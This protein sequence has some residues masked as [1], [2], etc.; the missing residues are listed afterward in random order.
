MFQLCKN[1]TFLGL[2]FSP[3]LHVTNGDRP[4]PFSSF[5]NPRTI[6]FVCRYAFVH[7]RDCD[8]CFVVSDIRM[9]PVSPPPTSAVAG[10]SAAA[11]AGPEMP[12]AAAAGGG[13]R[14]QQGGDQGA[15][16][17]LGGA[18]LAS[19]GAAASATSGTV[20]SSSRISSSISVSA[21]QDSGTAK[22]TAAAAMRQ[23][24]VGGDGE[25]GGGREEYPRLS[26]CAKPVSRRCGVCQ[27]KTAVKI[28]V[29]HPLSDKARRDKNTNAAGVCSAGRAYSLVF[30]VCAS[31]GVWGAGESF[32]T[33]RI[34]LFFDLDL[35]FC[36]AFYLRPDRQP[37]LC[38]CHVVAAVLMLLF[39]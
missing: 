26:F 9:D 8:H 28:T 13:A 15:A 14:Q 12:G 31:C 37:S 18:P 27:A 35:G 2:N 11:A 3:F 34:V 16:S 1:P 4:P 30:V 24:R 17:S 33:W 25:A 10:A 39:T 36:L 7:H 32:N 6:V 21:G 5:R 19:A 38:C 22:G 23:T 29:G 20:G